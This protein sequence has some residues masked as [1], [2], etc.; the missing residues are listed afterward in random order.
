MFF[1][2]LMEITVGINA[3]RSR[4][5]TYYTVYFVSAMLVGIGLGRYLRIRMRDETILSKS[6]A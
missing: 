1:G 2:L 6:K 5:D 3:D 4:G